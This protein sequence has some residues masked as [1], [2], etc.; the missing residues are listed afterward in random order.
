MS[1]SQCCEN[2]PTLSSG[3]GSGKVEEIGGLS[4]YVSDPAH[5]K[6][7]VILISDMFGYEAPLLRKLADKVGAAGFC[8]VVPD[9]FRGDPYVLGQNMADWL[10]DHGTDQGFEDAKPVIEALKSKGITKIGAAGFCWG[11][12]VAVELC[13][14]PYVQAG[15]LIHPSFVTV[16]DIQGVKVPLSILAAEIDDGCPPE[17][18]KQFEAALNAMPEVDSFVK[19]FAGCSHGWAL[20][21]DEEDEEA[22]KSAEEAHKDMLEWFVK[23]LK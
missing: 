10:T 18:V 4:S 15:V 8:A 11:A 2:P 19:I 12:K 21:Y 3:S 16:E 1:G 22:V 6:A 13:K 20:R 7:V 14:Y 9:F 23:H 17:L 5:S